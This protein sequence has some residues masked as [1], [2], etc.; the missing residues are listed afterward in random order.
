M[1]GTTLMAAD[2][3][4]NDVELRAPKNSPIVMPFKFQRHNDP[5]ELLTLPPSQL[6]LNRACAFTSIWTQAQYR[7]FYR[8]VQTPTISVVTADGVK[9]L[10]MTPAETSVTPASPTALTAPSSPTE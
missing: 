3:D 10:S 2:A 5:M 8:D 9:I 1:M 7:E 4:D 6:A